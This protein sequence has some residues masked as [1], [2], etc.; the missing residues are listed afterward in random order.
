MCNDADRRPTR[1]AVAGSW[2]SSLKLDSRFDL[3]LLTVFEAIY[4]RA[5]VTLAARHLNLSQSA[6]SHAL[7]RLRREFGDQLFVRVGSRLVP[8]AL[9]RSIIEPIRAALRSVEL[10]VVTASHF[11]PTSSDR[12]FRIAMRPTTEVRFFSEIVARVTAAAPGIHIVSAD[13]RRS[14]LTQALARGEVDMALDIA[15]AAT[16][17]LRT[18]PLRTDR[19]VVAARR[20]HLRIDGELTRETYLAAGHVIASPRPAGLGPEDAALA[21][22][23]A[24]RRIVARCQH[25]ATAWNIVA[26]S[27]LILTLPLSHAESLRQFVDLQLLPLPVQLAPR[28]L[29]L[30]WHEVADR[31]HGN[32]WLRRVITDVAA[33]PEHA[34]DS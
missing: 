13:F 28:A 11:D 22:T 12:L 15:S 26:G 31:D 9:A 18:A 1:G 33:T 21:E 2:T 6:I 8:T 7:G 32:A 14:E 23:G 5:S 29:N 30:Y 17:T 34:S 10:A 4:S 24:E 16:A 27:D 19:L 25:V 20:G 3:N